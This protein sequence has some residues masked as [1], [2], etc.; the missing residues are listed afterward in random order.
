MS[1]R[2][3][4]SIAPALTS[5]PSERLV[6]VERWIRDYEAWRTWFVR[7]HN[8]REP[9]IWSWSTRQRK[10]RPDPP[11]WLPTTCESLLE[12]SGVLGHGCR[13]LAAW[14]DD[15][16]FTMLAR[17]RIAQTRA[18]REAPQKT[19]WWQRVHL[20]AF[21]PMTQS[22]SHAYGVFGTHVTMPLSRRVGV[23][24]A[25]GAILLRVPTRGGGRTWMTATDW[26]MSVNLFDLRIPGLNRSG[27]VHL[28][29]ARVWLLG[30]AGADLSGDLYLAGFSM[31]F[32]PRTR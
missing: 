6:E 25:P 9:G 27:T 2:L 24:L 13:V 20:D 28:N 4:V 30:S 11:A 14:R 21:W 7:W 17:E 12:D 3:P 5:V 10:P 32:N 16:F 18:D 22:G 29:F 31:T 26:G 15:D 19:V 1:A 8:R 23:F